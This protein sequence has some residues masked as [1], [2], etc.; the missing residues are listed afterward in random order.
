MAAREQG[1]DMVASETRIEVKQVGVA[2]PE[3]LTREDLRAANAQYFATLTR[4][5]GPTL[6]ARALDLYVDWVEQQTA[7]MV[8]RGGGVKVAEVSLRD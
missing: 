3:P 5:V 8:R 6:T 4:L 1:S 7:E 2:P